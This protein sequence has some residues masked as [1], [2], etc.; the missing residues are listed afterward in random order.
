MSF[1]S[2]IRSSLSIASR[3]RCWLAG[4]AI[5]VSLPSLPAIQ[6]AAIWPVCR[7]RAV[8]DLLGGRLNCRSR[9]RK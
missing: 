6:P 2:A 4:K 5:A 1:G 9:R 8:Q 3:T 7:W